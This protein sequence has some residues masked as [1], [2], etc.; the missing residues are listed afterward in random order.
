MLLPVP[1][2]SD[3]I[4]L[5]YEKSGFRID[6]GYAYCDAWLFGE[7]KWL[8]VQKD[9]RLD[10]NYVILESRSTT[11]KLKSHYKRALVYGDRV[12]FRVLLQKN[13]IIRV[14]FCSIRTGMLRAD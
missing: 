1:G 12:F 3:K 5:N 14:S 4:K 9:Q 13:S 6:F 8:R 7:T 10:H 11:T 2:V